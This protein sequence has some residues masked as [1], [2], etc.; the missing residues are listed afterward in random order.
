MAHL[1]REA[2]ALTK[3]PTLKAFLEKRAAAF[4][5]NDYY[6]S[7]VAWMEL[8]ASIEPTIGP[9]E[10]YEDDWFNFKAA[11]EA[12]VTLT[13]AQETAQAGQVQRR[14]AGAGRPPAHRPAFPSRGSWAA[15]RPSAWS[16]WCSMPAMPTMACRPLPSTCRTTSA[17]SAEGL[18]TH[19]AEEHPACQVRQE[20]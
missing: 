17:W 13:D 5:S 11:F 16:T 15:K 9:Y 4:T 6:D 10:V 19:A 14:A 2:A 8:D 7:D 20:Y 18:K 1:L 3:Q 12:F